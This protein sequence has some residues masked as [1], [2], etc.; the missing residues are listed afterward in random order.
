MAFAAQIGRLLASMETLN[1]PIIAAVNGL[2]IGGGLLIALACDFIYASKDAQFSLPET[3][4]G[5]IPAGGHHRLLNRVGM[6]LAKELIASGR[7]ID[8]AQALQIRLVNQV[9]APADLMSAVTQTAEEIAANSPHA[10]G[11]SKHVLHQISGLGGAAA[12]RL[13]YEAAIQA[14]AHPDAQEGFQAFVHK[15]APQWQLKI[16]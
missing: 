1:K 14:A 7:T 12:D 13:E 4:L 3:K 16:P 2:A 6:G 8:A 11:L 15:R 9:C 10:V 5:M